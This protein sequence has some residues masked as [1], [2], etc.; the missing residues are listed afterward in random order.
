MLTAYSQPAFAELDDFCIARDR[1]DENL[2]KIPALVDTIEK[3]Q[4][5]QSIAVSMLHKHFDLDRNEYLLKDYESE[6]LAFIKPQSDPRTARVPY[7]WKYDANSGKG[8]YNFRPLEFLRVSDYSARGE[9]LAEQLDATS[10]FLHDLSITLVEL[11]VVETF[12]IMTLHAPV[13]AQDGEVWQETTDYENRVLTLRLM[14]ADDLDP[15]EDSVQTLWTGS[16]IKAAA[17]CTGHQLCT[18]CCNQHKCVKHHIC[19]AHPKPQPM[20]PQ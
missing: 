16:D 1:A 9:L 2:E 6:K 20:A 19:Q 18:W 12:G 11:D 8:P 4:L 3:H 5:G 15:T 7:L 17:K 13:P 14:R 10:D